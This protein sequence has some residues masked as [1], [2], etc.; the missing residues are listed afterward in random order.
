MNKKLN[1]LSFSLVVMFVALLISCSKDANLETLV[2]TNESEITL[3]LDDDCPDLNADI[4]DRCRYIDTNG[5]VQ[6]GIVNEDCECE[7]PS[8]DC[9]EL[10]ANIG[11]GCITDDRERGTINEDCECE[12]SPS[13]HDCPDIR[14]DIGD[15]CRFIDDNGEIVVGNINEDCECEATTLDCPELDGNIGDGCITDDRESCLLYT[16]D[17]ADE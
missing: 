10:E 17:A 14:A 2:T 3:R 11:D 1:L 16:S 9:P 4:G 13:S 7:G 15:L 6:V 12:A 8:Y 5:N